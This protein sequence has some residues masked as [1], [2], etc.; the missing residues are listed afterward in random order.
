MKQK[1]VAIIRRTED[2]LAAGRF[3]KLPKGSAVRRE[4]KD[5]LLQ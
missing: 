5:G 2:V 1:L 3:F 4:E